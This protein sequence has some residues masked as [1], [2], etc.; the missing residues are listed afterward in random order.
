MTFRR[1]YIDEWELCPYVKRP[2]VLPLAEAI[3]ELEAS[4][5]YLAYLLVSEANERHCHKKRKGEGKKT[6]E[7]KG[8][9]MERELEKWLKS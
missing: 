9:E 2:Y 1:I 6:K 7:G 4:F 5:P 8:S 3:F